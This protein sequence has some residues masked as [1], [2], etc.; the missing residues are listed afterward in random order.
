MAQVAPDRAAVLEKRCAGGAVSAG[1]SWGERLPRSGDE[2]T[3]CMSLLPLPHGP[4]GCPPSV[5]GLIGTRDSSEFLCQRLSTSHP[6]R[7]AR[8]ERKIQ[9]PQ[10]FRNP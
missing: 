2:V 8:Q 6:I 9:H 4:M 10:W 5:Y 3:Q 7:Y 1:D